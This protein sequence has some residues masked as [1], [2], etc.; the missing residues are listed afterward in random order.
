MW[1]VP[2]W[3]AAV[4][5]VTEPCRATRSW[6]RCCQR[7][8][9]EGRSQP[10]L[11]VR[12]R[13]RVERRTRANPCRQ[14]RPS[15]V[16]ELNSTND[17]VMLCGSVCLLVCSNSNTS[18]QNLLMP[19]LK[20]NR[21]GCSWPCRSIHPSIEIMLFLLYLYFPLFCNSF[22]PVFT[23]FDEYLEELWENDSILIYIKRYHVWFAF[24]V[25]HQKA[26]CVPWGLIRLK[27]ASFTSMSLLLSC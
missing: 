26:T 1:A 4:R 19:V 3:C 23:C 8:S 15:I 11:R 12:G 9:G 17:A 21:F 5:T 22:H 16:T 25:F 10:W 24:S 18:E 2:C 20:W 7:V 13:R 27:T 6:W 14:V